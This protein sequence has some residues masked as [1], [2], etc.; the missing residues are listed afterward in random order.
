MK[1]PTINEDGTTKKC[2]CCKKELE[3]IYYDKTD[4]KEKCKECYYGE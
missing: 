1:N 3:R 2:E 4:G